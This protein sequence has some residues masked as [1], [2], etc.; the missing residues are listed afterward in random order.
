MYFPLLSR[1]VAS[2]QPVPDVRFQT[3]MLQSFRLVCES[4]SSQTTQGGSTAIAPMPPIPGGNLEIVVSLPVVKSSRLMP[5]SAAELN[6]PM[7]APP[8]IPPGPNLTPPG[9][10]TL[11]ARSAR[12]QSPGI[13]PKHTGTG[14]APADGT[15]ADEEIP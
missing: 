9:V 3:W 14:V 13:A 2:T 11:R 7:V 15:G 12:V 4:S 8:A 1:E 10:V 5:L 6:S